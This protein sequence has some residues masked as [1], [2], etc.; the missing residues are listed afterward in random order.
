MARGIVT[1]IKKR[2][3]Y[4]PRGAKH[5][6]RRRMYL[7]GDG[8]IDQTKPASSQQDPGLLEGTL[9]AFETSA[10]QTAE[11]VGLEPKSEVQV[12]PPQI[13]G[14]GMPVSVEENTP[15]PAP[16]SAPAPAPSSDTPDE[17]TPQDS[18]SEKPTFMGSLKNAF[19]GPDA[20]EPPMDEEPTPSADTDDQSV[21]T[22]DEGENTNEPLSVNDDLLQIQLDMANAKIKELTDKNDD[23]T[24]ELLQSKDDLISVLKNAAG[25]SQSAD[26]LV[27][28]E[29]MDQSVDQDQDQ[30]Q[31]MDQSVEQPMYQSVEQPMDQSV[32]QPMDQSVEQ[33]MEQPMDQSVEAHGPEPQYK[34]GAGKSRRKR[35]TIR[36]SKRRYR[37]VYYG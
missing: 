6:S 29:P 7:G 37:Y 24:K 20:I 22:V 14:D 30:D 18:D 31:S 33:P 27:E 19:L 9:Q 15:V 28:E 13:D 10:K 12:A 17:K 35:R 16:V 23:L 36:K 5:M 32:E 11:D 4:R 3:I 25:M 1:S 8:Q 26:Q 34:G 2:S 21:S